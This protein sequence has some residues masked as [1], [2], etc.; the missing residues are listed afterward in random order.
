MEFWKKAFK[1]IGIRKNGKVG[2]GFPSEKGGKWFFLVIPA[3]IG[4]KCWYYRL[5]RR[6]CP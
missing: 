6:A 2:E 1:I 4:K 3:G 5:N